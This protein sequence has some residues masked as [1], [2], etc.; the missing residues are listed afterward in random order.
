MDFQ[1]WSAQMRRHTLTE[2]HGPQAAD[3]MLVRSPLLVPKLPDD[4]WDEGLL[5]RRRSADGAGQHPRSEE[6]RAR[7]AGLSVEAWRRLAR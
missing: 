7:D 5:S 4:L 6:A 3:V 2:A 1:D